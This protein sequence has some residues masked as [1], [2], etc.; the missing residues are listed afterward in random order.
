MSKNILVLFGGCSPEHDISKESVQAVL[1]SLN[2]NTVIPVYI[3]REGKWLMYDGKLDN[4]QGINW[5]KFGTPAILSP[6]RVNRGLLRIV[7]EKVK[8]VPVDV[9]FPVMHGPNGED[10]TI[11]GLCELAGIPYVGCN[12]AASAVAMDKAIMKLVAKGLKIPQAE[13]L[14][15]GADE[16]HSDMNAALKKIRYKLGYPCFVKPAVGGS[17]IGIF[18][19]SN[20][21][22]L[23]EAIQGALKFSSRIVIEKFVEG[24]EIEVAI[25]GAGINAKASVPGEIL[26]AGEFYDFEAKYENTESKTVVPAELPEETILEV[27][28]Y[29]LE[30]FR[31][32]GGRGISRVDFF[33]DTKGRV[34]FNEINT[35]PGFTAISMY[36]KMWE[37][38]GI[39]R[40]K[41][42][43]QL[44]D[45]AL[46]KP[47]E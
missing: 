41:L 5:E 33:L 30:I 35:V 28:K 36:T 47:N 46:E 20:R 31:A 43:E 24:R 11:Q 37:A 7:S 21:K 4:I 10:G 16:I 14:V 19:V 29:A 6:D 1:N 32:I 13:F 22:E 42:I 12:V 45:I 18:K 17:S 2:G 25:L 27:Q 3:T 15:F 34:I 23:A 26:S 39:P 8:A 38:S 44:I 9:V 40:Q